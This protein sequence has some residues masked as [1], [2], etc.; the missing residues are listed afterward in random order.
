MPVAPRSRQRV[1]CRGNRH[2]ALPLARVGGS[3]LSNMSL[4]GPNEAFLS[5]HVF[6]KLTFVPKPNP[7]PPL[8]CNAE[9]ALTDVSR[10][11]S[12]GAELFLHDSRYTIA[13]HERFLEWYQ[14]TAADL[15]SLYWAVD[16]AN[17]FRQG[18]CWLVGTGDYRGIIETR[19]DRLTVLDEIIKT[20]APS[21]SHAQSERYDVSLSFAGEQRSFVERVAATLQQLGVRV[22]YDRYEEANLWG[23]DLY[24]HLNAVYRHEA[25]YC[26]IFVSKEYAGK[27]WTT[28]ERASAQARA[29]AENREYILPARF[30]D[31][32]LPGLNDTTG[33]IDLRH[34]TPERLAELIVEKLKQAAYSAPSPSLGHPISPPVPAAAPTRGDISTPAHQPP[35]AV[36]LIAEWQRRDINISSDHHDYRL[37]VD[38]VN[39][40]SSKIDDWRIQVW[41]PEAFLPESNTRNGVKLLEDYDGNYSDR[42][43]RIYPG[44]RL[45]VFDID[46][47]VEHANWPANP[48]LPDWTRRSWVVRVKVC[49][50]DMQPWEITIPMAQI[51]NF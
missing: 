46:Y 1:V 2:A 7:F 16:V 15:E 8:R 49:A 39:N 25:K 10:R 11:R 29:F 33:Y 30:D 31:T 37:L 47:F 9:Q 35:K 40:G 41:F 18:S 24:A 26:V 45:H 21:T 44:D 20:L 28:H 22:F 42:A 23:K 34:T 43:K 6:A 27:Q 38:L 3:L 32:K 5:C 50:G 48:S 4:G 17:W 19:D 36:S 14:G 51:Q 12:E 13:M